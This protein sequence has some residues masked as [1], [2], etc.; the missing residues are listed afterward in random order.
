MEATNNQEKKFYGADFA[1][2]YKE[3]YANQYESPKGIG[4]LVDDTLAL[5]KK[6]W[7]FYS[8]K[9]KSQITEF[10]FENIDKNISK[11]I[12]KY[13][14]NVCEYPKLNNIVEKQLKVKSIFIVPTGE[15]V[16]TKEFDDIERI[17][18]K[19]NGFVE[20]IAKED[21]CTRE[22]NKAIAKDLEEGVA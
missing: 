18:G 1:T 20:Y 11:I 21:R 10:T 4:V 14:R 9:K 16:G 22:L 13:N 3:I 17:D 2:V 15:I 5:A 6:M 19:N 7:I 8:L 12:Y